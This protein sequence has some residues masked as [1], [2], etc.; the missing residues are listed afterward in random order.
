[1]VAFLFCCLIDDDCPRNEFTSTR[2][3]RTNAIYGSIN[4]SQSNLSIYDIVKTPQQQQL[5]LYE[6]TNTVLE[7]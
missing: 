1:M 3:N 7:F 2:S 5:P 6:N 4:R